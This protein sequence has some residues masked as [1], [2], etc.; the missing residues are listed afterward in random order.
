MTPL[1]L[2]ALLFAGSAPAAEAPPPRPAAR[3][4]QVLDLNRASVDELCTLP[5]IGR[6]K[7]EAIVAFRT[8]R[9]FTRLT[10]LLEVRGIGRRTLDQLRPLV[11]IGPP[12]A[13]AAKEDGPGAQ[14]HGAAAQ[15]QE[16]KAP[17]G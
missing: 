6:K 14:G 10:Q 11:V 3:V 4:V 9:P 8:K 2:V 13:A 17:A 12:P 1:L 15:G 16:A 5:G 7:A